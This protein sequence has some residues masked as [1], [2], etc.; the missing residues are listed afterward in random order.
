MVDVD[1]EISIIDVVK[2]HHPFPILAISQPV[3]Y[4]LE[5]I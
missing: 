3:I 1:K 4:K 5:D 2:Y